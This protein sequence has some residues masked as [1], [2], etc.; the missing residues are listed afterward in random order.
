MKN[1]NIY[2]T[3]GTVPISNQKII[4]TDKIYTT[5]MEQFQY[6]IKKS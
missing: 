6:Q 2:H 5:L 4:E 3:D 1:K